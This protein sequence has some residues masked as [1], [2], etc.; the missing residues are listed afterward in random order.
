SLRTGRIAAACVGIDAALKTEMA[1]DI[2]PYAAAAWRIAGDPRWEWLEG[3]LDRMVSVIDLASELQ[4]VAGLE[5]VLRSLHA[6][7]GEFLDQSVRGGSQTDGPLFTNIDPRIRALRSTIVAAVRQHVENLP[8]SDCNHP[9]L[10]PA[11]DGPV[12]F[13]G[14]WS[15]FLKG[16]GYHANH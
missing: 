9:L 3:D 7:K 6:G 13:S 1:L 10:G 14:S 11:R 12:R 8:A 16:G 4:D 2:W 15:V 5:Q